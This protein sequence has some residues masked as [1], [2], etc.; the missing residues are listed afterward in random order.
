MTSVDPPGSRFP[1]LDAEISPLATQTFTSK[2]NRTSEFYFSYAIAVFSL[3][4]AFSDAESDWFGSEGVMMFS[5][6]VWRVWWPWGGKLG[7]DGVYLV[8]IIIAVI[9]WFET[10][11]SWLST[12]W[13]IL[14][15]SLSSSEFQLLATWSS[16]SVGF[17]L[18]PSCSF[19]F[20]F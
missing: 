3:L 12:F 8:L 13:A 11:F 15:M 14:S 16:S 6:S 2:E 19:F 9:Y 7:L 10:D 4:W 18:F 20:S 1:F 17:F 5:V